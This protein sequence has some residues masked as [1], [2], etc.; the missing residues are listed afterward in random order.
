M[1]TTNTYT[2][3]KGMFEPNTYTVDV[4]DLV[5][6]V[7]FHSRKT[8]KKWFTRPDAIKMTIFFTLECECIAEIAE[9]VRLDNIEQRAFEKFL[10]SRVNALINNG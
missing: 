4:F 2:P 5:K 7:E 8:I 6:G 9:L 1:I 10:M 3:G